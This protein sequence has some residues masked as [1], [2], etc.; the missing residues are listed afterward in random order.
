MQALG[1]KFEHEHVQNQND[2]LPILVFV[3]VVVVYHEQTNSMCLCL[4]QSVAHPHRKRQIRQA[5]LDKELKSQGP[6]AREMI[7]RKR[8]GRQR[9]RIEEVEREDGELSN[10]DDDDMEESEGAESEGEVVVVEKPKDLRQL[11][12]RDTSK[13]SFGIFLCSFNLMFDGGGEAQGPAT[14]AELRHK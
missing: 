10:E 13:L 6:D 8:E 7:D 2:F 4:I 12:N 9:Q 14:A 11:L 1:T 3:V 5:K